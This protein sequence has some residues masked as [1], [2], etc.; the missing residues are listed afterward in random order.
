MEFVERLGG[1][2]FSFCLKRD[3]SF[4]QNVI[5]YFSD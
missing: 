5:D 1:Y 2:F 3:K 4:Y